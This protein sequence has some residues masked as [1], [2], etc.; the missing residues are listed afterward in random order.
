MTR[1]R[2]LI[3]IC[4]TVLFIG[5][6]SYVNFLRSKV[7][8]LESYKSMYEVEHREN[9]IFRAK[10]SLWHNNSEVATITKQTAKYVKD[11]EDLH[12]RF[13]GV[14]KRLNNLEIYSTLSTETTIHKTVKVK[15]TIIYNTDSV[16]LYGKTGKYEDEWE[17]ATG[18]LIGDSL[19]L[20]IKHIDKLE[21]VMYWDRTWFLGKKKWYNEIVSKN[22][23]TIIKSQK[24]IKTERKRGL[25]KIM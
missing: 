22:P 24:I 7:D 17:K 21:T 9:K 13:D 10:D 2:L 15:D 23:N 20:D 1:L 8:N 4:I 11:L 19:I 16:A 18:T 12:K 5:L 3:Y 6:L 14:N 25:F